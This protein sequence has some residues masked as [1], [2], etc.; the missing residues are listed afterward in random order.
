MI[1]DDEWPEPRLDRRIPDGPAPDRRRCAARLHPVR[2]SR[3]GRTPSRYSP[4]HRPVAMLQG[5]GNLLI[6]AGRAGRHD[7]ALVRSR[8]R[9]D[10]RRG[11]RFL[12]AACQREGARFAWAD[13]ARAYGDVP[14]S[15]ANLGWALR[16]AYSIGNSDMRVLLKHR[17]GAGDAAARSRENR[18]PRSCCRCRWPSFSRQARIAGLRP[19]TK[20]FRAA[21]KLTAMAGLALQRVCRGPW[22]MRAL[23]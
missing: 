6:A 12:P 5:A 23:P 19:L 8:L 15:R 20:L 3:S 14:E 13:E 9:P 4:R 2:A 18:R 16:R 10:R 7:A 1:D 17:P 21:G 22:R 11:P